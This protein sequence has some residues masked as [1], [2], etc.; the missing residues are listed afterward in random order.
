[1]LATC[2]KSAGSLDGEGD[3]PHWPTGALSLVHADGSC[4]VLSTDTDGWVLFIQGWGPSAADAI[5]ALL[6]NVALEL[7]RGDPLQMY[8]EGVW[9]RESDSGH[10]PRLVH[11]RAAG[12]ARDAPAVVR[13]AVVA[14]RQ[15]ERSADRQRIGPEGCANEHI[16]V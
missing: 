14:A 3:D 8:T 1:M 2:V 16:R 11:P 15:D 9:P 10:V 12:E 4:F 13:A 7:R 5:D 6:E